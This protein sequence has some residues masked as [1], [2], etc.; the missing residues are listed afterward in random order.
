MHGPELLNQILSVKYRIDTTPSEQ[1]EELFRKLDE[2]TTHL[3]LVTKLPE[4]RLKRAILV[5]YI[6]YAG[7]QNKNLE[8]GSQQL[9]LSG[10][11]KK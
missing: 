1:C 6:A 7:E 4:E 8:S 10:E 3:Q 2:L 11:E 9:P 5:R